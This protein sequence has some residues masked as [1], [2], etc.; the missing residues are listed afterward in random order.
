MG[1]LKRAQ[2]AFTEQLMRRQS[3]DI[4]AIH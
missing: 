1:D 4:F 2:Q 3:G